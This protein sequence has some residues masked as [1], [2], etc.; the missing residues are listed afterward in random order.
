MDLKISR[1]ELAMAVTTASTLA[2]QSQSAQQSPPDELAAVRQQNAANQEVV[3]K[4]DVAQ[5]VEPA[6]HFRA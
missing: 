5:A 3:A 6:V 2:A 1:R 4:F